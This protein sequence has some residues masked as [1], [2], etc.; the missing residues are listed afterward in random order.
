MEEKTGI[1]IALLPASADWTDVELPHMTLVFCGKIDE[2]KPGDFNE[3]AKDAAS[4][5]MLSKG[6]F[7]AENIGIDTFGPPE[8]LV[9]ALV[10]RPTSE[11]MAA[12][13]FLEKWNRS[14]YPDFKP[15]ITIGKHPVML[16]NVSRLIVF[17]RLS[18]NWGSDSI[19]FWLTGS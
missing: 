1:M 11:I 3:M 16:T 2:R 18:V 15:H 13:R 19:T 17:N 9:D 4:I 7:V 5:A 14:D 8:E 12:R 6:F 10:I